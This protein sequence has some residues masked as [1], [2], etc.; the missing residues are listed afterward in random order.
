MSDKGN[1]VEIGKIGGDASGISGGDN[2]GVAGKNITGAAGGDVSGTLTIAMKQLE[3]TKDPKALELAELLKQVKTAI[4]QPD[5]G[6]NEADQQK[7]LKHLETLG[8]LATDQK[9]PDLLEK[10]GDALDALPTI[11]KR[12]NNLAEFAE[13]YL[14][15]FTAGVKAIFTFWGI[16]L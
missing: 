14:P 11:I 16:P 8:K 1:K 13:K 5:S 4:E 10:A 6:L 2:S 3:E 12:G 7:A 15:T 9:N